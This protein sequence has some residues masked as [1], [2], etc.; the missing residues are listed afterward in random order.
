MVLVSNLDDG[1]ISLITRVLEIKAK[2]LVFILVNPSLQIGKKTQDLS[3][4]V[5]VDD[6]EKGLA[7]CWHI[8]KPNTNLIHGGGLGKK[9]GEQQEEESPYTLYSK[10]LCFFIPPR[11]EQLPKR[12]GGKRFGL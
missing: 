7:M 10:C 2:E 1:N 4:V 8:Q 12:A 11:L 6:I 5:H 9:R 3:A